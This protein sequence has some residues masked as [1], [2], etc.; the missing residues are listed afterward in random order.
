MTKITVGIDVSKATLDIALLDNGTYTSHVY[1]NDK[2]GI[3]RLLNWLKKKQVRGCNVVLEAT[4]HYGDL[5]AQTVHDRGYVVYVVN[6]ARIKDYASSQLRRAKT[7]AIDA[8]VIAHF[9]QSQ[10]M[11]QWTP[12]TPSQAELQAL[13]RHLAALKQSRV[14][15]KNRLQAGVTSQ[16]VRHSLKEQLVFLDKQIAKLEAEI[17][18]HIERDSEM[19]EQ[20]ELLISIKGIGSTTAAAFIAEVPDVTRF[21]SASQLAAY[22]GV[23]PRIRRSGSSV[24][25]R[26]RVSKIGNA[27]LRALLFMPSLSARSWNP[28]VQELVQRLSD[29]GKHKL[30]IIGAVTRKLLHIIY[31]V[32]KHKNPFDPNYLVNTQAAA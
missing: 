14:Q 23:T 5:V 20:Y 8:Q 7:D 13:T 17:E 16:T 9:G 29:R 30:A 6:P 27:R 21:D 18:A 26:S 22:A 28:L 1:T 4:G 24:R 2:D 32:L 31:G 15:E 3:R 25:G 10:E 11:D 12:P 19:K